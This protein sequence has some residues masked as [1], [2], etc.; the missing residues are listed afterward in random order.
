M[1][2]YSYDRALQ[3]RLLSILFYDQALMGEVCDG[4]P[5]QNASLQVKWLDVSLNY[6]LI[7]MNVATTMYLMRYM[8]RERHVTRDQSGRWLPSFGIFI[9]IGKAMALLYDD[10]T[11]LL[12]TSMQQFSTNTLFILNICISLDR[13]TIDYH[14]NYLLHMII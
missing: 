9:A 8:R 3:Q 4:E 7:A 1:R 2:F 5:K 10:Q 14:V 6:S 13:T 12:H 11:S